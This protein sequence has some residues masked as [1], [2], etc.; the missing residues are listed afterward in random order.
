M[1]CALS[2]KTFQILPPPPP[3]ALLFFLLACFLSLS[4]SL[5]APLQYQLS[6]VVVVFDAL[7]ECLD[8]AAMSS[9]PLAG[10]PE[11]VTQHTGGFGRRQ[12]VLL[13]EFGAQ[14]VSPIPTMMSRDVASA[15]LIDW[16]GGLQY[17]AYLISAWV[18][19]L[20]VGVSIQFF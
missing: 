10:L 6:F 5:V 15:V 17:C 20:S 12:F 8:V 11:L 18:C 13:S 7:L 2:L 19:V 1:Q 4:L 14:Y 3:L 9:V 16:V